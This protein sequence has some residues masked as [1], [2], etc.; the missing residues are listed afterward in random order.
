MA[1]APY[2]RYPRAT[3]WTWPRGHPGQQ[4]LT[5][6]ALGTSRMKSK[7]KVRDNGAFQFLS[8]GQRGW[9]L[10]RRHEYSL[11]VCWCLFV[12][13]TAWFA[14]VAGG[15]GGTGRQPGSGHPTVRRRRGSK[16][17]PPGSRGAAPNPGTAAPGRGGQRG[18]L[19]R[20]QVRPVNHRVKLQRGGVQL[21][22]PMVG[23]VEFV[24]L[25]VRIGRDRDLQP[26]RLRAR[27]APVGVSYGK[28]PCQRASVPGA[29]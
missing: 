9:V 20:H 17:R 2:A 25:V 10:E 18:Q 5:S 8:G 7:L 3:A 27:T 15:G 13:S 6:S 19:A 14:F 12:W 11:L 23:A 29:T 4:A 21:G 16:P 1:G 26:P 24:K 28:L 22:G